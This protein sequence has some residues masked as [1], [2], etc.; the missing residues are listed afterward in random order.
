MFCF[1]FFESNVFELVPKVLIGFFVNLDPVMS[2]KADLD[3]TILSVSLDHVPA[4]YLVLFP[5]KTA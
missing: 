3:V 5:A 4:F 1:S 2:D